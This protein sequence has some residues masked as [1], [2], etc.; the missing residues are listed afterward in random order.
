[1]KRIG[2]LSVTFAAMLA[3]ACGVDG[4]RD[5]T[6]PANEGAAVGT[7]GEGANRETDVNVSERNFFEDVVRANMAEVELGRLASDRAQNPE[8]KKFA[9]MMVQDHTKGLETLKTLGAGHNLTPPAELDEKHRDM[10]E[11]LSKQQGREFDREYM[12]AM[13]DGHEDMADK[14]EPRTNE[15]AG[16]NQFENKINQWAAKTLPTVRQHLEKAKQLNDTL[17]RRTTDEPNRQ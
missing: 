8:V 4:R 11:R 14:L 6:T 12:Q 7:A 9:Q 2:I 3:I 17:G 13:V 16:E 1:M 5:A 10:R 15:R